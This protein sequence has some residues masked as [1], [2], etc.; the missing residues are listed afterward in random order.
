MSRNRGLKLGVLA[1][2]LAVVL[3]FGLFQPAAAQKQYTVYFVVHGGIGHPFWK[4]VEQGALDADAQLPD[5]RVIYTGPDPY[6]FEQFVQLVEAA[7]AA[8]PDGL[9]VTITSNVALDEP[10][11]RAMKAGI[12]VIAVNAQDPRPVGEK[13]PY[14]TY[15]GED[16]YLV[17]QI[18][19]RESMNRV[20]VTRA[21]FGNHHPGAFHIEERGQGFIDEFTAAGIPAEQIDVTADPVLASQILV[22][23]IRA[24]PD[25]NVVMP[26]SVEEGETFAELAEQVGIK[27]GP[28]GV[29]ISSIDYSP[30]V[31]ELMDQ[32]KVAFAVDQEQ[33]LQGYMTV[34][35]MY[36]FL[37]FGL[38][39]PPIVP[40]G[41][42][43]V[44]KE[45]IQLVKE[46]AGKYR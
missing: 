13:I 14:L 15:V 41:P 1:G 24:H 19:A 34:H 32:G 45:Q 35:F 43:I 8:R 33:Y 16:H 21:V 6:N 25:T 40:T 36:A 2:L 23:Y 5:V 3:V 31:L 44:T 18:V 38:L 4:V 20:D 27:L 42:G 7:I 39:P 28:D 30:R 10:L 37:R 17:G 11:R 26:G 9:I 12:A 46:L 22:D 29:I